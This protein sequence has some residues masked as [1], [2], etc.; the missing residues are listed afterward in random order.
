MA[1]QHQ[2]GDGHGDDDDEDWLDVPDDEKSAANGKKG[3]CHERED[4]GYSSSSARLM[5]SA[6]ENRESVSRR[7]KTSGSMSSWESD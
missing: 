1:E 2:S 5:I 3:S 7:K 6:V 4:L